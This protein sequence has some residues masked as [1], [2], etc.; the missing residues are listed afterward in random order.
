MRTSMAI[1]LVLLTV[2]A[3]ACSSESDPGES[4]DRPGGTSGT[5]VSGTVCGKPS[6]KSTG[7]VCI[8]M[9]ADDKD[10]PSGYGCKGVDGTNVKG[11]RFKD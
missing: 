8:P 10:C 1:T 5:C 9:C 4:C 2:L 3:A 6:D 7:I 11:C